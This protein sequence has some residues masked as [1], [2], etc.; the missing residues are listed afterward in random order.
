MVE[1]LTAKDFYLREGYV[2][3]EDYNSIDRDTYTRSGRLV[4]PEYQEAK[5]NFFKKTFPYLLEYSDYVIKSATEAMK[6][7]PSSSVEYTGLQYLIDDHW[8][9]VRKFNKTLRK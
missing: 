2:T 5:K 9:T 1:F 7:Y 8:D 4:I 6:L 3:K